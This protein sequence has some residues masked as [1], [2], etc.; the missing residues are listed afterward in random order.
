M[1]NSKIVK[2][3]DI[4]DVRDGTHDSPKYRQE[5]YPLITS[6]NVK[7]GKID[8]STANLISKE[9]F[10]AV[11]KRSFV[12]DGDI[13]MPMIGTIGNP[14]I[15]KKEREFAIKNVAL[16]KFN[17][18]I[19][20]NKFLKHVLSS[21]LFKRYIKKNKRGGTQNFLSLKDI[22]N[23]S[24]PL[25]PLP[26]QKQIV[27]IL[28][29]AKNLKQKR[30]ETN[31]ETQKIIQSLFYEM[32]GDPVK[33]EKGWGVKTISE[34]G[35]VVS[36]STPKTTNKEF[37]NGKINWITPAELIDGDN[38]YYY[39]TQ[40]KISDA[41]LKSIGNRL[42]PI[43]TVMLTTRAPIGKVAIAGNEMCSNQ[44]FKN[45]ICNDELIHPVY[46]YVWLLTRK[47]YLNSIG[48]GATFK[49]ISKKTVE[50]VSLSVPPLPLQEEFAKKV[51]LIESIQSKQQSST[52]EINTLF[53]ALMQKAFKGELV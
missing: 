5:G 3:N 1:K 10:D 41:G 17:Q 24:F 32:F 37:W 29:K 43:G 39:E 40:R 16:I 20:Y 42:F 46:L 47:D 11:N 4:C 9:D 51:Q 18:D 52:E 6:K 14:I 19:I 21:S 7:D 53:D 49:E 36:G 33:K 8:F 23:F 31:K 34:I 50:N 44:G 2:L 35:E 15:V 28:E 25:P 45:I 13:I 30:E 27:S 38:Y 26:V 22:R 48:T 12:D